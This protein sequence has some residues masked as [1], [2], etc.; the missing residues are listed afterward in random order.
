[1]ASAT[2]PL[3]SANK[4]EINSKTFISK[5]VSFI[6]EKGRLVRKDLIIKGNKV[7]SG[8]ESKFDEQKVFNRMRNSREK[9]RSKSRERS[10]DKSRLSSTERSNDGKRNTFYNTDNQARAYAESDAYPYE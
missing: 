5:D 6:D 1:M 2:M 7:S 10:I 8:V 4:V 9:R 3:S